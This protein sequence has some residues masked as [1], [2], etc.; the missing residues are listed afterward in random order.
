MPSRSGLTTLLAAAGV[1]L[2]ACGG[3]D[4]PQAVAKEFV[5][6][7]DP[8]KCELLA[9]ETLERVTGRRGKAALDLCKGNVRGAQVPDDAKVIESEVEKGRAEV[10]LIANQ[11]EEKLQLVKRDGKWLITDFPD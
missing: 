1:M 4:S 8:G 10:E 7:V 6:S 5:T 11:R 2:A 3:G 9:P